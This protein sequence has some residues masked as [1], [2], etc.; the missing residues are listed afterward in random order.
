MVKSFKLAI[1][2]RA[3]S[4]IVIARQSKKVNYKRSFIEFYYFL[5]GDS[6][7]LSIMEYSG[8]WAGSIVLT[9]KPVEIDFMEKKLTHFIAK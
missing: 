9:K 3:N 5:Y 7:C 8:S 2:R 1:H 6:C 4:D